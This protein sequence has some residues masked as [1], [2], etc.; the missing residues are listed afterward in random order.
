[1][2]EVHIQKMRATHDAILEYLLSNPGPGVQRRCAATFGVTEAWLSV[3]I[4]SDV[5][6]AA[7]R[8]RRDEL[9]AANIVPLH[10]KMMGVAHQGVDKLAGIMEKSAD[11]AFI[12][13]TTDKILHRLGY[14]PKASEPARAPSVTQNNFFTVSPAALAS[15]RARCLQKG[16]V[17]NAHSLEAPA[18]PET[19]VESAERAP[20]PEPAAL[21][22]STEEV[23]GG[24][25]EGESVREEGPGETRG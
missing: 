14:A 23:S 20:R 19:Y 7:Y 25:G 1:M 9:F 5:F 15:A 18:G 13:D 2:A 8:D 6:Q 21:S 12:R 11:P 3:I 17:I 22:H 4:N 10:E 24:E 16:A